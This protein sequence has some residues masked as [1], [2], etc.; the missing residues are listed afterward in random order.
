[1]DLDNLI[2]SSTRS[3]LEVIGKTVDQINWKPIR[4]IQR[5]ETAS[6]KD[7]IG[8]RS[9]LA[10][11]TMCNTFTCHGTRHT[12][13]SL[14]HPTKDLYY[15]FTNEDIKNIH[16]LHNYKLGGIKT[17][18]RYVIGNGVTDMFYHI[19]L[20]IKETNLVA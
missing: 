17:W 7:T 1:M 18:D 15:E 16:G 8:I 5:L 3:L 11:D 20:R 10:T 2:L 9:S 6:K 19:A 4:E 14:K 12:E 13:P